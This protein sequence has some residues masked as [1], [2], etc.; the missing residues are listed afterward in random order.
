MSLPYTWWALVPLWFVWRWWP[1]VLA[2]YLFASVSCQPATEVEGRGRLHIQH[3]Q[4]STSRFST[5]WRLQG[6]IDGFGGRRVPVTIHLS[7]KCVRPTCDRDYVVSG[8]LKRG[9]ML[10]IDPQAAWQEVPGSWSNAEWRFQLKNRVASYLRGKFRERQMAEFCIGLVTGDF[11]EPTLMWDFKRLGLAHLMAISGF[12]FSLVAMFL[13]VFVRP[14]LSV[15]IA[16]AVLVVLLSSYFAFIGYSP[17]VQRAWVMAVA[18]LVGWIFG[19]PCSA[20]NAL[21]IALLVVLIGDPGAVRSVGFQFSFFCTAAIL[22]FYSPVER[23]LRRLLSHFDVGEALRLPTLDQH[24]LVVLAFIR[25]A[26]AL[27]IAVHLIA[28]PLTLFHFGQFPLLSLLYNLFFPLIVTAALLLLPL[29]VVIGWW[30]PVEGLLGLGIDVTRAVPPA[31][32]L[33]L[34]VP[35]VPLWALIGWGTLLLFWASMVHGLS[36]NERLGAPLLPRRP[37][38]L[39][40][41][42][43]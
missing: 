43:A 9:R 39:R 35:L 24:G 40:R 19:R 20:L 7:S 17:S 16:G 5:G 4:R 22:L 21:G 8:E 37:L 34:R 1:V 42:R 23:W 33:A 2:A 18:V 15:R 38:P 31:L 32:D 36:F 29:A 13:G 28:M 14:F 10:K 12:H 25:R 11:N 26:L 41:C 3:V 6:R 30:W 27:T